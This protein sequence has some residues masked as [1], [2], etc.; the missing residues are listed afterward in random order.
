MDFEQARFITDVC[1]SGGGRVKDRVSKKYG[2]LFADFLED[3]LEMLHRLTNVPFR[4]PI[5]IHP[6]AGVLQHRTALLKAIDELEKKE[7]DND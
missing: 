2:S 1:Y 3:Y 5:S 6:C 4:T 7:T